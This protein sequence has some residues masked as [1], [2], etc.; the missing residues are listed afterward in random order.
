MGSALMSRGVAPG[1]VVSVPQSMVF[2][3]AAAL[4]TCTQDSGIGLGALRPARSRRRLRHST[5]GRQRLGS[6]NMSR[7]RPCFTVAFQSLFTGA[8]S[9]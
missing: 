7:T 3:S 2:V 6:L 5:A 1:H 4:H 8:A 9:W